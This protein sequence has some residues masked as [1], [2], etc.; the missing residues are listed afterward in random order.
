M[1]TGF[2]KG[3]RFPFAMRHLILGGA[4]SGKTRFALENARRLADESGHA[5]T[6]VATAQSLDAQMLLRIQRHQAERPP[7]W[8]TIEAP[9]RLAAHLTEIEADAIVI[10]D[11]MTLWLTN[12]MLCDFDEGSADAELPTLERER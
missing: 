10:V 5:V 9:L 11:C 4:R 8:R 7:A 6:Y 12:I 3:E 1:D 2:T